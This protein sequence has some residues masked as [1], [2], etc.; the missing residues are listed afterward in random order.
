MSH[1]TVI[2]VHCTLY[3]ALYIHVVQCPNSIL[4]FSVVAIGLRPKRTKNIRKAFSLLIITSFKLS[5]KI[6]YI[7]QIHFD[8][9]KTTSLDRRARIV[10]NKSSWTEKCRHENRSVNVERCVPP[11]VRKVDNLKKVG[12]KLSWIRNANHFSSSDTTARTSPGRRVHSMMSVS[13]LTLS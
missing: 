8:E 2:H 1:S 3:L 13:C 10:Q 12:R 9:C 7:S 5:R 6:N 4:S 11:P